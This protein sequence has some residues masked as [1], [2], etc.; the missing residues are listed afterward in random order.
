MEP[1]QQE[2]LLFFRHL[3]KPQSLR[4]P[5][6]VSALRWGLIPNANAILPKEKV[7]V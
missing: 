1:Q 5:T 2:I 3:K 7:T 6:V 4:Q